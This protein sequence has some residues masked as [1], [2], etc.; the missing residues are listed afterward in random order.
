MTCI[1]DDDPRAWTVIGLDE[2]DAWMKAG[3]LRLM[4]DRIVALPADPGPAVDLLLARAPQVG[5]DGDHR[6]VLAD[7]GAEPHLVQAGGVSGEV[8]RARFRDLEGLHPLSRRAAEMLASRLGDRRGL[9]GAP[10]FEDA[11]RGRLLDDA[12]RDSRYG[13]ETVLAALGVESDPRDRRAFDAQIDGW[14]DYWLDAPTEDRSGGSAPGVDSNPF[15]FQV[16][17]RLENGKAAPRFK[18]GL[19]SLQ[20]LAGCTRLFL[21]R[22]GKDAAFAP[23][24]ALFKQ[25]G[26]EPARS[27]A[28][29]LTDAAFR[30][31]VEALDAALKTG[32]AEGLDAWS[33]LLFLHWREACRDDVPADL[34]LS[35]LYRR[36]AADG[37]DEAFE[38]AAHLLGRY[39]RFSGLESL[40]TMLRR[41]DRTPLPPADAPEAEHEDEAREELPEEPQPGSEP[42]DEAAED[43]PEPSEA[44]APAPDA[45]PDAHPVAQP[46]ADAE[47]DSDAPDATTDEASAPG[48]PR[49]PPVDPAPAE[50]SPDQAAGQ[51]ETHQPPAP[52]PPE[53]ESSGD[54]QSQG[55]GTEA[56]ATDEGAAKGV[57]ADSLS[58]KAASQTG[59]GRS[60]SGE[61]GAPDDDA[62]T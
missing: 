9:L 52:R 25:A 55:S 45:Q 57:G 26:A 7:L 34:D 24:S 21:D 16:R 11:W 54:P 28:E 27:L 36:C 49:E 18:G 38:T 19:G 59:G 56:P 4:R 10:R 37:R 60:P 22:D 30:E 2:L 50:P 35:D 62:R 17:S 32:P 1:S 40:E 13:G 53:Q 23:T 48:E 39:L 5:V 33:L 41:M 29:W 3:E 47:G 31:A 61:A 14:I 20:L 51:D 46:E 8:V 12:C 42:Q 43:A 15:T 44:E 58:A 6:L